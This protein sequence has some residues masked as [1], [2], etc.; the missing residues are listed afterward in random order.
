MRIQA[1]LAFLALATAACTSSGTDSSTGGPSDAGPDGYKV[2]LDGGGEIAKSPDGTTLC[3]MGAC[4][5][6]TDKGCSATEVCLPNS[7]TPGTAQPGCFP[8]GTAKDGETC[9]GAN[10]CV[11]GYICVAKTCHKLCCGGDWSACPKPSQ[12]CFTSIELAGPNNTPLP[13][14][15]MVCEE[16]GTC[17]P[18]APQSCNKVGITCQIVDGTGAAACVVD[19]KGGAGEACPC[20]GGFLCVA[21]SCRRLCKAVEGGGSPFCASGEGD[22]VHFNRDPQGVGECTP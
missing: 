15:A 21:G 1:L 13:T 16:T 18:L 17:D 2:V 14:G 4:N 20:Q 3:P 19:G 7:P 9:S 5:Y 12:H 22:C 6:Q 11:S 10:D 8:A